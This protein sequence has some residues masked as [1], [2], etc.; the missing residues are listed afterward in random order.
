V[1]ALIR[2]IQKTL[3][4][5]NP[6]ERLIVIGGGLVLLVIGI[7][8]F[9]W[10]P[11]LDKQVALN[12]SIKSQQDL[13]QWMQKSAAEVRQYKGSGNHKKLNS[14]AMQSVI[15][16]TAKSALPGALI[17]RIEE[18]RQQGVQVW[19]EKVAFDDVMKWLG[20]LQQTKGIRVAS[21]VSERTGQ[22]GRVNV[23]L[24]LKA[25]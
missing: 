14:S 13:Y 12:A 10:E 9:A 21:L 17:K 6:R 1:N 8:L 18:N 4:R 2:N 3:S 20:S 23:R 22:I 24:V 5:L 7:Y 11:L 16:R 15:N 25:G 19:I